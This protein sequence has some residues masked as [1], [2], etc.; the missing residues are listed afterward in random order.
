MITPS[1]DETELLARPLDHDER[2]A[3]KRALDEARADLPRTAVGERAR[4]AAMRLMVYWHY[5]RVGVKK[6][7]DFP[8]YAAHFISARTRAWHDQLFGVGVYDLLTERFGLIGHDDLCVAAD[9]SQWL[10]PRQRARKSGSR[11]SHR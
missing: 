11:G 3:V 10:S 4:L 2:E 6:H 5:S 9:T 1:L 7:P 8:E